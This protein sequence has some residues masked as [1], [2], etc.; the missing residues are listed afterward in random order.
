MR[1]FRARGVAADFRA[2]GQTGILI[3]GRGIPIDAVVADFIAGAAEVLSPDAPD[4]HWDIVEGQGSI[5]LRM[6]AFRWD[7]C[8]APSPTSSC[9]ATK[10]GAITWQV[11]STSRC[12]TC[13]KRSSF[14]CGWDAARTRQCAAQA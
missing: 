4:E 6:Q 5:I 10:R 3:A 12:R 7:F 13:R 14:I 1:A 11:W 8:M 2:T 9:S